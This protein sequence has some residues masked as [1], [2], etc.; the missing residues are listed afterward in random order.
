MTSQIKRFKSLIRPSLAGAFIILLFCILKSS[1][2]F[3]LEDLLGQNLQETFNHKKNLSLVFAA[4]DL[5]IPVSRFG[6]I[7]LLAH[8]DECSPDDI[9]LEFLGYT[10]HEP[11]LHFQALLN[12]IPGAYR[13]TYG[14]LKEKEYTLENR[15][16]YRY[17]LLLNSRERQSINQAIQSRMN[18]GIHYP[19]NFITYNCAYYIQEMI[20]KAINPERQSTPI[21]YLSPLG[22]VHQLEKDGRLGPPTLLIPIQKQAISDCKKLN[23]AENKRLRHM[24]AGYQEPEEKKQ[25]NSTEFLLALRSASAYKFMVETSPGNSRK[26]FELKRWSDEELG[27]TLKNTARNNPPDP[28]DSHDT[29]DGHSGQI[30]F[31]AESQNQFGISYQPLQLTRFNKRVDPEF[32]S[33]M[34]LLRTDL[35]ISFKPDPIRVKRFSILRMESHNQ[36][37]DLLDPFSRYIDLSYYNWSHITNNQKDQET[38]LRFGAGVATGTEYVSLGIIPYI[39]GRIVHQFTGSKLKSD[40]GLRF[41][42]VIKLPGNTKVLSSGTWYLYSPFL[43]NT[44]WESGIYKS[45]GHEGIYGRIE[46]TGTANS[47]SVGYYMEI[48]D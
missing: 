18:S 37:N 39:G 28:N 15:T 35:L 33:V 47:L 11:W 42:S 34:D 13:L 7:Y 32:N 21:P 19:Y 3:C 36:G 20:Q 41:S 16:L 29:L 2:A 44:V 43:F 27:K 1:T 23:P 17:P 40:L 31:S 22:V 10:N 12:T 8:D 6:H 25:K 5:R 46:G 14:M 26:Y 4:E 30:S 45:W 38:V 48:Q 24:L 9:A